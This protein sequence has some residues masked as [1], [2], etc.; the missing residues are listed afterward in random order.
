VASLPRTCSIR[1][2]ASSGRRPMPWRCALTRMSSRSITTLSGVTQTL[3]RAVAISML[4][5]ATACG[6][7]S[8]LPSGAG[9]VAGASDINA[10]AL[11]TPAVVQQALGAPG[12]SGVSQ[13][14]GATSACAWG[15]AGHPAANQ[16]SVFVNLD[17]PLIYDRTNASARRGTGSPRPV[18]GLGYPA[19][20]LADATGAQS[21]YIRLSAMTM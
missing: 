1:T 15:L 18:S 17:Q 3:V 16:S 13:H 10:C 5:M 4:A 14:M 20:V 2:S 11:L 9:G 21:L 8:T 19:F 12:D 7:S 6:A